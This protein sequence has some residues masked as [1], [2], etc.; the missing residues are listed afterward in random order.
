MIHCAT[1]SVAS[2]IPFCSVYLDFDGNPVSLTE[3][4]DANEFLNFLFD[5]METRLK[6][7]MYHKVLSETFGGGELDENICAII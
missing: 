1:P 4:M 3:Q 6:N 2:P 5:R 7:T